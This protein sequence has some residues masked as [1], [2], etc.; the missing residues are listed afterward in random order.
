[1]SEDQYDEIQELKKDTLAELK[2]SLE[3][4]GD[5]ADTEL[6]LQVLEDITS[7]PELNSDETILES[8]SI[9]DSIISNPNKTLTPSESDKVVGTMN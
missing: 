7:S 3:E 4:L 2:S 6:T 9:L 5:S 8:K 1:M